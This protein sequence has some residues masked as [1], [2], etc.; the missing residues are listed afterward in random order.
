MLFLIIPTRRP[1]PST[2]S[3]LPGAS[4]RCWRAPAPP[5]RGGHRRGFDV[6][7][8]LSC[9]GYKEV[10]ENSNALAIDVVRDAPEAILDS[11]FI[12]FQ[13][14]SIETK[15]SAP[16][17]RLECNWTAFFKGDQQQFYI[18]APSAISASSKQSLVSLLEV[19]ESLSCTTAWM[20]IDRARPDF[21]SI[22]QTFKYLGFK[23]S[24]ETVKDTR[25]NKMFALLRYDLE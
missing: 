24:R 14:E 16:Q 19:A 11:G 3:L 25:G 15:I 7:S 18:A 23:L 6:S 22:V 10:G 12:A 21:M 2:R 1:P 17:E 8:K 4:A 9:L 5:T 13:V 20:Y